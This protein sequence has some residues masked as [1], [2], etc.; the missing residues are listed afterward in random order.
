MSAE[1]V[2]FGRRLPPPPTLGELVR[3]VHGM[4]EDTDNV[5]FLHPH[6]Q[7]RMT[8]RGIGMRLL[9]ETL[10]KGEGV[11][12]PTKDKYGDW[13][14]KMRRYVAGRRVQVIVAVR[15]H[16]FSVVTVI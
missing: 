5:G 6:L 11:S 1:I 7:T 9:L 2:P 12:G 16:D 15:E 3:Q 4:A 10:R 8:Q 13:R 14:I